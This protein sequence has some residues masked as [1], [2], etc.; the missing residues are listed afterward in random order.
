MP[1]DTDPLGHSINMEPVDTVNWL[2]VN[3]SPASGR[4]FTALV[5]ADCFV[6]ISVA[7]Q[8]LWTSAFS[9]SSCQ[10]D[11]TGV[12]VEKHQLL[13]PDIEPNMQILHLLLCQLL[14]LDLQENSAFPA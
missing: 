4:G 5:F 7:F 1:K 11:F 2:L 9:F 12:N 6:V 14:C 13:G 3:Q 8:A 10:V